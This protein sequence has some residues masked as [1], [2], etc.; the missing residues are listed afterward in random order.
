[1]DFLAPDTL[2]DGYGYSDSAPSTV[3]RNMETARA[4]G[5]ALT[6]SQSD[7]RG[8]V[9]GPGG[10]SAPAAPTAPGAPRSAAAPA[11]NP[12]PQRPRARVV[13]P[14]GFQAS[15]YHTTAS[16]AI[17]LRAR[18]TAEHIQPGVPAVGDSLGLDY[19]LSAEERQAKKQ[20]RQDA[21][22]TKKAGK[23]TAKEQ[24]AQWQQAAQLGL[25]FDTK[26][27]KWY[28]DVKIAGVSVTTGEVATSADRPL[29]KV[30]SKGDAVKRAQKLLAAAGF[31]AGSDGVFTD[32][33]KRQVIAFQNDQ[34]LA[35]DGKIGKDT[36]EALDPTVVASEGSAEQTARQY[37]D[38]AV[39]IVKGPVPKGAA[40]GVVLPPSKYNAFVLAVRGEI[41]DSYGPFPLPSLIPP[42]ANWDQ[43]AGKMKAGF[44]LPSD[45]TAQLTKAAG[46]FLPSGASAAPT[47]P[48]LEDGETPA[49]GPNWM[50][51]G[52]AV[53]A[54]VAVGGLAFWLSGDKAEET[55]A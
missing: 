15:G 22:A 7:A 44:K 13:G 21:R 25:R 38:N 40:R 6:E 8:S 37:Q 10:V 50:L 11:Y 27:G 52:G 2:P 9:A 28:R 20:A 54:V 35:G 12:P 4:V 1:M 55:S 41:E 16:D 51:I 34:G 26:R 18:P 39:A 46:R 45:L 3:H 30:G 53:V 29:L 36:W 43:T 24:L 42:P 48:L 33:M 17:S 32:N 47:T 5:P 23:A 31:P 19:G 14:P 49:S